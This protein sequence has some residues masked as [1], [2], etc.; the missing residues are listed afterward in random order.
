MGK[1]KKNLKRLLGSAVAV[2]LCISSLLQVPVMA[3]ELKVYARAALLMDASNGRILYEENGYEKLP[4]ASTTKIMTC[5]LALEYIKEHETTVW[6]EPVEVSGHAA[7]MPKVKLGMQ[8]GDTFLLEDLL[9]SLML[10]SHN[11][12][13]VAI[14]EYID[15][16]VPAFAQ[17]M[18]EK[19]RSLG[20]QDTNFITP[21]GLDAEVD[22]KIHETTAADL[23]RIASYALQNEAFRKIIGTRAYTFPELSGRR[24]F[25]VYNKDRFLDLMDGAIGIK[26]GFTGKAGYCFVGAL[27][28]EGKTFVSV[29]L[30]SGWPPHKNWKWEDTKTLMEYGLSNYTEKCILQPYTYRPL[31]VEDGISEQAAIRLENGDREKELTM[32]LSADDIVKVTRQYP[33]KLKA[34]VAEGT[35]IGYEK[36]FVN[37]QLWRSYKILTAESVDLRTYSYCLRQIFMLYF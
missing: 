11:D 17:R 10:E 6:E 7:S 9:Y 29:V 34:P 33:Q 30:G 22:G 35:C 20:C 1:C 25:Q 26:T 21:N 8:K 37:G 2:M 16:S 3:D 36:Y 5:I 12:T 28:R 19:A 4:M 13:A 31:P 27:E 18:N 23:A 32:L 24:T 14:A 15:G